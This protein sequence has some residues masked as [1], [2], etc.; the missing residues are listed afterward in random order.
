MPSR[1]PSTDRPLQN[2]DTLCLALWTVVLA[3]GF[4]GAHADE[5][6]LH[7]PAGVPKSFWRLPCRGQAGVGRIDPIMS[8]GIVS[9]HVHVLYGSDGKMGDRPVS[10]V[11]LLSDGRFASA[12]DFDATGESLKASKCTSC[13]VTQDKSAYWTPTLNF[14]H[15]NGTTVMVPQSGGFLA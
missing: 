2:M 7:P 4:A 13:A 1:L 10:I 15:A 3:I 9:P 8:P 11:P 6:P 12:I 5:F 14:V